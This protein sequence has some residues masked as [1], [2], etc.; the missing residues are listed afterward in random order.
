[1]LG[2]E[3]IFSSGKIKKTKIDS[4]RLDIKEN[5]LYT[6]TGRF[7]QTYDL[8]MILQLIIYEGT[9]K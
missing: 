8:S 2:I 5:K 3:D 9:K 6:W 1:M 7:S 4:L